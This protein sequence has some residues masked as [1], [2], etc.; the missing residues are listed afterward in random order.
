MERSTLALAC[1]LASAGYFLPAH[2]RAPEVL[3]LSS[4]ALG[5]AVGANGTYLLTVGAELP[6]RGAPLSV[7]Q[8]GVVNTVENGGLACAAARAT[9]GSDAH[10]AYAGIVV[11]CTCKRK[12]S[13]AGVDA[14]FS[15]RAYATGSASE[16]KVMATL[17]LPEGADGT[18]AQ[19]DFTIGR[20]NPVQFAPFPSWHVEGALNTSAFLCYGGDKSHLFTSHAA[21][22]GGRGLV[23]AP[24]TCFSQGNG[25]ATLLWG[26]GEGSPEALVVGPAS[27]FHLNY[28]TYQAPNAGVVT[29]AKLWH[30][31]ARGDVVLC[32]SGVCDKAQSASGYTLLSANEGSVDTA[33]SGEYNPLFF[34]WSSA[35]QDNWVTNT[36]RCPGPSYNSCGNPDGKLYSNAGNMGNGNRIPVVTYS[37]ANGTHHMAAA[38]DASKAWVRARAPFPRAPPPSLARPPAHQKRRPAAAHR[39]AADWLIPC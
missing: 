12:G 31:V 34:S 17:S 14:L 33:V 1:L 30:D 6:V 18:D 28:H 37:N 36:S 11:S 15:W 10:G 27:A 4:G 9:S 32:L 3:R 20:G 26:G 16:G 24:S 5:L 25:P 39:P 13:A 21:G 38:T 7:F 29:Q 23:G 19:S 35:N 2:A 22:A 8:G